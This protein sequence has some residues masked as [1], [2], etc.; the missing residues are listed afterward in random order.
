MNKEVAS[1][2]TEEELL[3][4]RPINFIVLYKA[5]TPKGANYYRLLVEYAEDLWDFATYFGNTTPTAVTSL[6]PYNDG[7]IAE[8]QPHTSRDR[9]TGRFKGKRKTVTL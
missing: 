4:S 8:I 9:D 1:I 5:Q 6:K 7:W 2:L 3:K